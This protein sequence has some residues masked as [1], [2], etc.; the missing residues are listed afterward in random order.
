MPATGVM[1]ELRTDGMVL[2]GSANFC[3]DSL[4]KTRHWKTSGVLEVSEVL[5]ASGVPDDSGVLGASGVLDAS[6]VLE[7]RRALGAW[8]ARAGCGSGVV[9]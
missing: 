3:P 6:G 2:S 5:E 8:A 7:A 9:L 1:V 4:G